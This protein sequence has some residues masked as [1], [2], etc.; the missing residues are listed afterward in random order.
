ML[1]SFFPQNI[2]RCL[3]HRQ[4][5]K[6]YW[7]FYYEMGLPSFS[8]FVKPQ[9]I[10]QPSPDVHISAGIVRA[11]H[12]FKVVWYSYGTQTIGAT[13]KSSIQQEIS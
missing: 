11:D 4:P 7:P 2:I 13:A 6:Y 12:G 10:E 1:T 8:S 3:L 9:M 5:R